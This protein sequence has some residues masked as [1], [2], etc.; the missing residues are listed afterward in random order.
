MRVT[1]LSDRELILYDDTKVGIWIAKDRVP[2]AQGYISVG[3]RRYAEW[4]NLAFQATT[5]EEGRPVAEE[6]YQGPMGER[7]QY[8]PPR[9]ILLRPKVS[10]LVASVIHD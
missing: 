9:Q 6:E 5:D 1:N 4:Q 3:S 8:K 7:P 2:R 10:V